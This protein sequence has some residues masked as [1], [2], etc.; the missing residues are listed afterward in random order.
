MVDSRFV[1]CRGLGVAAAA[2]GCGYG[3][4]G[5]GLS[6]HMFGVC[7]KKQTVGK[8]APSAPLTSGSLKKR[9]YFF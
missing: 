2:I 1:I 8:G 9:G 7:V 3:G 5:V 6:R 4:C